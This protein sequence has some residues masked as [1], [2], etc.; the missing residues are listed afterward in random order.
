MARTKRKVNPLAPMPGREITAQRIY[1]AGAYIRLS[2][3]DSGKKG[4]DTMDAQQEMIKSYIAA[5]PDMNLCGLYCDN[6]YTGTNFVEV[7]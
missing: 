2:M 5:Q 4:S 3:E 6:G 7:R 1:K